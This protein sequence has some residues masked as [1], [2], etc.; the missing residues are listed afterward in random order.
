MKAALRLRNR[1]KENESSH[2]SCDGFYG[3]DQSVTFEPGQEN[4][5][6]YRAGRG[7]VQG[8]LAKHQS[9]QRVGVKNSVFHTLSDQPGSLNRSMPAFFFRER[10]LVRF[11]ISVSKLKKSSRGSLPSLKQHDLRLSITLRW[12]SWTTT[13]CRRVPSNN[14]LVVEDSQRKRN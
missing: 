10:W 5:I 14:C 13:G 4:F 1:K 3:I 6:P 11:T 9:L 12:T 2:M 7:Q 8:P